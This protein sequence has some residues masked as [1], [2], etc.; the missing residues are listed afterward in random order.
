[1]G[2]LQ[3]TKLRG[4][5]RIIKERS[6]VTARTYSEVYEQNR[7]RIYALAFWM[8]DNELAA[9]ELMTNAFCRAFAQSEVPA[10]EEIDCALIA[11]ASQYMPLGV[12]RLG[13]TPC[14]KVLSVRC[15]TMRIDLERLW[16]T[17]RKRKPMT[18]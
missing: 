13:C 8:M 15:H 9:E 1:M 18:S 12:L 3:K 6:E 17:R 5:A 10:P 7:H 16:C 14:D 11:E 4:D 2:A